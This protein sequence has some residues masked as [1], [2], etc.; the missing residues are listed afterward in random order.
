MAEAEQRTT[1]ANGHEAEQQTNSSEWARWMEKGGGEDHSGEAGTW[2]G[3][4]GGATEEFRDGSG[5]VAPPAWTGD[6]RQFAG[7]GARGGSGRRWLATREEG[8]AEE[9]EMTKK[10]LVRGDAVNA[11]GGCSDCSCRSL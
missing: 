11:R 1:G 7:P 2:R 8:E 10:R 6:L 5:V 3:V 4:T 9:R